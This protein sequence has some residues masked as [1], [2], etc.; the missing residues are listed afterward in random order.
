M[1]KCFFVCA[2]ENNVLVII[3]IVMS[4]HGHLAVLA[5]CKEDADRTEKDI[6]K[7]YSQYYSY[8]YGPHKVLQGTKPSVLALDSDWYVRNTLAY[9]PRNA[10]D[11]GSRIEDYRWSG[12]RGMFSAGKHEGVISV[13]S[14][15]RRQR[16]RQFRTHTDLSGVPW[17][18]EKNGCVAP[19]S[20][21][22]WR[23]LE[24]AFCHD[25][26]FFLKTIGS[27]NPAEMKQKLVLNLSRRQN[28]SEF[29][30]S[31]GTV[32]ERWFGK[33]VSDLSLEQKIRIIPYL[34]RCYRTSIPQLARCLHMDRD[35][36]A[37]ILGR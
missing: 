31:A 17:Y 13:A 26:A 37:E 23:Y 15:S 29:L 10:L 8:R 21:L 27:L 32:A 9:I 6:K 18:L 19:A 34:D 28:D 7:R 12:Y 30:L 36:V 2:W 20:A 24:S 11:T 5:S 1:E 25:Q 16:E 4:N 14:M 3:H 35:K 22:D 33:A